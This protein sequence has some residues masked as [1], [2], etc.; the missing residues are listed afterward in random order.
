MNNTEIVIRCA[1][2]YILMG[3]LTMAISFYEKLHGE[4]EEGEDVGTLAAVL[5][6]RFGRVGSLVGIRTVL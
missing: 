1:V 2:Q 4:D 3:P 5:Q 6:G